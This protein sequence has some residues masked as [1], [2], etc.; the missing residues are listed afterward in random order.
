[1]TKFDIGYWLTHGT[2][3]ALGVATLA[4]YFLWC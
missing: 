3:I 4:W 2:L 1:M